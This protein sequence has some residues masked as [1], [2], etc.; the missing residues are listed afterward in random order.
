MIDIDDDAV[1]LKDPAGIEIL[2]REAEK[3]IK[4]P[5]FQL[6]MLAN[7]IGDRMLAREAWPAAKIT[8][9]ARRSLF[10]LQPG[11]AFVWNS[12]RYGVYGNVYRVSGTSEE[13]LESGVIQI[14]AEL[15]V[16][17]LSRGPASI[18][19]PTSN[20][21]SAD[22]DLAPL[23]SV[24]VMEIPYA[25][26]NDETIRVL[27]IAGRETGKE[28]GYYVYMSLDGSTYAKIGT[29]SMFATAGVLDAEYPSDTF[30]I[31]DEIGASVDVSMDASMMETISRAQMFGESNLALIGDEIVSFQ[32]I[33]PAGGGVYD[34]TGVMRARCDSERAAHSAGAPFYYVG[35]YGVGV[36]ELPELLPGTT[37]HF[38]LVPYTAKRA[39]DISEA[40]AVEVEIEGRC[41]KPY[42]PINLTANSEGVNPKYSTDIVLDWHAR[43]RDQGAGIGDADAVTDAS[44]TWEGY[45]RIRVYVADVLVRTASGID[46]LTWTYTEDMNLSDNGTLAASV[47]FSLTNYRTV[48]SVEYASAATTLTVRKE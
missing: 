14:S 30:E 28:T 38:K 2:G 48:A 17:Y 4:A 47:V 13:D 12:D 31:D 29:V 8:F 21:P 11:D 22:A 27:T 24:A 40:S 16:R 46:A 42:R 35:N 36:F 19:I 6:P 44:P 45:F 33:T 32:T 7:W 23:A 37:R 10:R 18:S 5:L 25:L 41:R 15:D 3:T 34:L 26:Q 20:D 39:G 1:I 43:L 9:Q